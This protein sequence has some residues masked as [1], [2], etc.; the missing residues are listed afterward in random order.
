MVTQVKMTALSRNGHFFSFASWQVVRVIGVPVEGRPL[1][2][3]TVSTSSTPDGHHRSICMTIRL[4]CRQ[5]G[6]SI[7]QPM[8]PD[9]GTSVCLFKGMNILLADSDSVNQYIARKVLEK[10]GC[11][12]FIVSSWYQ[13][14]ETLNSNV[15]EFH[16]LLIDLSMLEDSG[17]EIS[18]RVRRIRSGSWRLIIGLTFKADQETRVRCHQNGIHGAISKPIILQEMEDE[19]RRII[20]PEGQVPSPSS[21]F[22]GECS[23]LANGLAKSRENSYSI[24]LPSHFHLCASCAYDIP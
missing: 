17:H 4:Q 6:N 16:L 19:L 3:G 14:L 1:M 2:H 5:L 18:V 9:P 10:L 7:M 20:Q 21:T 8:Y 11:N 23:I 24:L 12:L 13:C 22:N 15:T